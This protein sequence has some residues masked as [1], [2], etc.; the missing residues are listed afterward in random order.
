MNFFDSPKLKSVMNKILLIFIFYVVAAASFNGFF[1][2]WTFRDFYVKYSFSKMYDGTAYRPFV[3]RQLMLTIAKDMK[4]SMTPETQQKLLKFFKEA[5]V[6]TEVFSKENFIEYYYTNT[7]IEPR[8]SIEYHIV[9]FL[10][11][12]FLFLSMFIIRGIGIEITKSPTAG[13]LTACIF[14]I[15]FPIFETVGGYF[16]DFGEIFFFSLATLLAIKGYWLALILI[17]PIAEYNKESFLFFLITLFP[18]V[19]EKLGI[20]KALLVLASATFFSGVVYL[21]VSNTY[22][23][24]NGGTTS[25]HLLTHLKY[26]F[27]NWMNLEITYGMFF[28]AGMFL[29][30]VLLI[31]WLVKCTWKKLSVA[32]KNHLKIALFINLPLYWLFSYKGELR[33]LSLLYIGFIAMLS[34]FVKEVIEFEQ[35]EQG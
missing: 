8:F 35:K 10:S 13:T 18:F 14:A 25:F 24:N 33:N 1:A 22:I 23:G 12:V 31:A 30:H 15:I 21:I 3:H 6:Y 17:A 2:K 28:G 19:K 26:L 9:Y 29:P 7:K 11:F 5:E 34:I 4:S 20:R 16:Y 32:W 27:K